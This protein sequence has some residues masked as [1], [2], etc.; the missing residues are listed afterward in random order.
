MGDCQDLRAAMLA[1][2]GAAVVTLIA[3]AVCL[4]VSEVESEGISEMEA[5]E[6][7]LKE[8]ASFNK[9]PFFLLNDG[10]EKVDLV[11]TRAACESA[12]L[13]QFH[14]TSRCK[15]YSFSLR[16]Q[17]CL[18]SPNALGF[19]GEF[20]FYSR[21]SNGKYRDFMGLMYQSK[22]YTR[23]VGKTAKECRDFCDTGKDGK[24][25]HC[26]GYSYRVR[27]QTCLLSPFGVHYDNDYDYYERMPAPVTVKEVVVDKKGHTQ[28]VKK[29]KK[30]PVPTEKL[31]PK[32]NP[33]LPSKEY[34]A[35]MA[36]QEGESKQA[37]KSLQRKIAAKNRA[38]NRAKKM[39]AE[40]T[41]AKEEYSAAA[42]EEKKKASGAKHDEEKEGK[43]YEK[44]Q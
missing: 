36:V 19:N 20:T 41:E 25:R 27:D 31:K 22:G 21:R 2:R 15:S 13:N 26:N 5:G 35:Q 43:V 3:V 33:A 34:R 4:N 28:I 7:G 16:K 10:A 6:A 8:S 38:E 11:T 12:C 24:G 18:V 17:D 23:Y 37:A 42:K 40:K 14:L 29:K 44:K 9:I 32:P 1:N 39:K 30:T